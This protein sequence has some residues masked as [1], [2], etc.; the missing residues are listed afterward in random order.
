MMPIAGAG[1]FGGKILAHDDG[2]A[3]HDAALEQAEHRRDDVERNQSV[4][5]EVEQQGDALQRRP[6]HQCRQTAEPV[7]DESRADAPHDPERHHQRQHVGAAGD[8][9]AEIAAIG[10][11]VDLRHRHRNAAANRSQ[12]QEDLQRPRRQAERRG[13]SLARR[14]SGIEERGR[15][16]PAQSNDADEKHGR[17]ACQRNADMGRPPAI[18]RD[19]VLHDRRPHRAGD[20]ISSRAN[21]HRNAAAAD[22]PV[23]NV[24]DQR[25]K[26]RR[27][28]ESDQAV[29]NGE[30]HEAAGARGAEIPNAERHGAE[31]QRTQ[32][33]GPVEQAA[34]QHAA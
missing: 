12:G 33:P 20:I 25:A 19:G 11:D 21:R 28:A 22:E 32:N 3:R 4:I 17:A 6:Q 26:R 8:A 16:A 15:R 29:R 27:A 31:R 30:H 24:R 13:R 2:V 18:E 5:E 34:H 1:F 14:G 9:V 10:D 23:R 7:G